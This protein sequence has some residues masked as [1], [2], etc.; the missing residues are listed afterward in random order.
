M[1]K[2]GKIKPRI[3]SGLME[4]LPEDQ[5]V[6]NKMLETIKKTYELFGFTPIETPAVEFTEVLL[7]K[8]GGET[9]KQVWKIA[10]GDGS[11]E[12]SLH[13]DLTVPLARYVAQREGNLIFPFR[14][15]QAQKV[16]RG[17]RNQKGRFREFYQCDIDVIGT[18]D[19]LVDAE[20][21]SVIFEAFKRLGFP[22]IL[23]RINNRKILNGFLE[24]LDCSDKSKEILRIVDKIEKQGKEKALRD[25]KDL[26]ISA[27]KA[28]KIIKFIEI[29]GGQGELIDKL[30]SLNVSSVLFN[31]GVTELETVSK[32]IQIFGIPLE[33][34]KIDLS[35]ARG[36]DYYTG[37]VYE[38]LLKDYPEIGS[39]F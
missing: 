18:T 3:P 17:E 35:I 32:A 34:F 23:I 10:K 38:T 12:L 16:W 36:L 4:L 14:R 21:P 8:S 39:A 7:T 28:E 11:G 25:F 27:N 6:F 26:G 15:Y 37:T 30:K 19:V 5:I 33:N 29:K 9:E 22:N 13:F 31:T 2:K 24:S 1:G 20:I